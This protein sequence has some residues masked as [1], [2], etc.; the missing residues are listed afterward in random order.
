MALR[1]V[2]P[3]PDDPSPQQ[4]LRQV[5]SMQDSLD[6]LE[7]PEGERP[8]YRRAMLDLIDKAREQI[9]AA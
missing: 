9:G 7:V 3:L 5:I 6:R 2:P 1:L 8:I 4:R